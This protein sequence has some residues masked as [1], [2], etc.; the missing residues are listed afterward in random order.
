MMEIPK[1][2][3][4]QLLS[5]EL[6]VSVSLFVASLGIFL[7]TWNYLTRSYYSEAADRDMQFALAGVSDMAALSQGDPADWEYTV[8]ENASAFGL[9][10]SENVLS[11][12]KLS[13]LQSLNS[14]HYQDVLERMGVGRYDLFIKVQS[15]NGTTLYSFG[16][17]P[18]MLDESVSSATMDRTM[19]L[20]DS[21]VTMRVQ[22]W[23]TKGRLI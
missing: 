21:V 5:T 18:N 16:M 20:N 6:I 1:K 15:Q 3:K 17:P 2:T 19:L 13:A 12:T 11:P 10:S 7:L 4:G 8:R 9:A 14:T 23:R 22:L